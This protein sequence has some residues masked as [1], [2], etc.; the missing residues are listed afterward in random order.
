MTE[1]LLKF[2]AHIFRITPHFKG[3][4][5]IG[6]S[7]H[8]MLKGS[9]SWQNPE[10]FIKL[11][12][13]VQLYIDIRSRTHLVPF[14]TGKRDQ[15]IISIIQKCLTPDSVV[16]DVG[17]NIGYYTI[18]ISYFL[19]LNNIQVHAF[20]PVSSNFDSLIKAIEKNNVAEN[21]IANKIALGDKEGTIDII[22]TEKGNSGNAVLSI[23]NEDFKVD[24]EREEIQMI[25]LDQYMEKNSIHRC[26]FIK[27]D[28]EGAEIFFIQGGLE[29]IKKCKPIIYGEFNSFFIR[30]FGFSIID[31][32]TLI[33]P[34]GYNVYIEDHKHPG[35]FMKTDIKKGMENLL[36]IPK[37]KDEKP[38][39]K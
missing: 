24:C 10:F 30:K 15:E 34:F 11:K 14:W 20:E 23:N 27:V 31:V 22:K 25:T 37:E 33:E 29:I 17:A 32:W 21:V 26:D 18:P 28:I 8:K 6:K 2:I 9:N 5:T 3:K 7:I 13:G 19:K 1:R 16:L 12:N 35:K 39:V 38:W 4:F 36:F